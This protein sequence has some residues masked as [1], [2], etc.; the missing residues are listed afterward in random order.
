MS[1]NKHNFA[2][3]NVL[4]A[5][6]LNEMDNQIAES[7]AA[8]GALADENGNVNG[9]TD[10]IVASENNALFGTENQIFEA[11]TS[12]DCNIGAGKGHAIKGAGNAVFGSRHGHHYDD[13][14][15]K[16]IAGELGEVSNKNLIFGDSNNQAAGSGANFSL[17]GGRNNNLG[18]AGN[19]PNSCA[20]VGEDC[21]IG[22]VNFNYMFG[23]GLKSN[24]PNT[25]TIGTYNEQSNY[26]SGKLLVVG[27]GTS[28]SAR[29]NVFEVNKNGTIKIGNTTLSE[30]QLQALL[31][32]S[33]GT[34]YKVYYNC[35]GCYPSAHNPNTVNPVDEY[36]Y[37][38]LTFIATEGYTFGSHYTDDYNIHWTV[39]GAT[40]ELMDRDGTE[41][42]IDVK[43]VTGDVYIT[44]V[45]K[46][47]GVE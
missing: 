34:G 38:A 13:G 25:V 17:I 37:Y 32:L 33:G 21:V 10:N 35:V 20:V 6:Q 39:S 24:N 40:G 31:A 15:G 27:N 8:I 26:N 45:A 5:E 43:N 11:S 22:G 29:S 7:A 3:G 44:V 47:V 18:S 19:A 12:S 2:N 46:F 30:A 41:M 23:K 9:G 1:Y 28:D 4:T 14:S 42:H 36:S 16:K